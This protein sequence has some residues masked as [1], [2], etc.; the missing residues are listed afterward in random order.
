MSYPGRRGHG[1]GRAL[2]EA[3]MD[4]ARQRARPNRPQHE[5]G[6]R[7]R[8]PYQS[9]RFTNSEGGAEAPRMLYHE[10]DLQ[11]APTFAMRVDGRCGLM[12]RRG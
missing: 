8:A 7:R 1:F 11:R 3:A 4:H 6:R 9:A 10:R 12:R 2:L 5:R